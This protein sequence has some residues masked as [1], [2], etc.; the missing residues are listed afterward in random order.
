MICE[1]RC[2]SALITDKGKQ[3][4]YDERESI[5]FCSAVKV[6]SDMIPWMGGNALWL[7]K[8]QEFTLIF[9]IATSFNGY[10]KM[11]VSEGR[12]YQN[13]CREI[14]KAA[15]MY[16]YEDNVPKYVLLPRRRPLANNPRNSPLWLHDYVSINRCCAKSTIRSDQIR[17][18]FP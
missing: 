17:S 18:P 9:S 10:Q 1:G 15:S 6:M 3:V 14:L 4:I 8:T 16:S 11:P 12:E 13:R 2:P 7:E 5:H